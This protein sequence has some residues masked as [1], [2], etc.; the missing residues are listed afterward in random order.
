MELP[1]D[2]WDKIVK[3]SKGS[4]D[5][6]VE[7]LD[8]EGLDSL[9]KKLTL[10]RNNMKKLEKSQFQFGDIVRIE[11]KDDLFVVIGFTTNDVRIRQVRQK[12]NNC[13]GWGLYEDIYTNHYEYIY[14]TCNPK[15]L[16]IFEKRVDILRKMSINRRRTP[17]K[18][19]VIKYFNKTYYD[20]SN[21][22]NSFKYE[23]GRILSY[24]NDSITVSYPESPR[25]YITIPKSSLVLEY[26]FDTD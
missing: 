10:K 15:K 23:T 17:E 8:I 1:H 21:L 13:T 2:I 14:M 26:V 18:G 22:F 3:D 4:I 6:Q 20:R 25:G 9:I 5:E 7:K 16:T 11:D 12:M 19:T 24:Y